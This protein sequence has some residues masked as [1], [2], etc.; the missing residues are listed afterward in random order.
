[1][2]RSVETSLERYL[3]AGKGSCAKKVEEAKDRPEGNG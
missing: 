3:S 1:M 2:L